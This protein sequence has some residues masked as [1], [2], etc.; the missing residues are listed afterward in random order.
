MENSFSESRPDPLLSPE[1]LSVCVRARVHRRGHTHTKGILIAN[2]LQLRYIEKIL[3][4]GVFVP[5]NLFS[6]L[7]VICGR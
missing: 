5:L 3:A 1:H 6:F 7:A 4:C 2:P